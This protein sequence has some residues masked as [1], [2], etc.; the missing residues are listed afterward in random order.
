MP[1]SLADPALADPSRSVVAKPVKS[2]ITTLVESVRD[3]LEIAFFVT[4]GYSPSVEVTA[5]SIR[6]NVS[7]LKT[8]KP[9]ARCK[10]W[11]IDNVS[12]FPPGMAMFS[13]AVELPSHRRFRRVILVEDQKTIVDRRAI[14]P[15]QA[16]LVAAL[17][18]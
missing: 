2:S 17:Q 8:R 13:E 3:T 18:E 12:Q 9:F 7:E 11:N 4:P 5:K 6:A 15:L 16:P 1:P 14:T 10:E